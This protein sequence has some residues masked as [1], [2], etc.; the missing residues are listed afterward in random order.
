MKNNLLI[1]FL[2]LISSQLLSQHYETEL[3]G[4][5]QG[6]AKLNI[7][8]HL[9]EKSTSSALKDFRIYGLSNQEDTIEVPYIIQS[10]TDFHFSESDPFK[11]INQASINGEFLYTIV[12]EIPKII[13]TIQLDISQNNFDWK[14]DIEGSQNQKE[15]YKITQNY[16]IMSIENELTDYKFTT[17]RIPSSQYKYFRLR[18]K[19]KTKPTITGAT[20]QKDSTIFGKYIQYTIQNIKNSQDKKQKQSVYEITL[21]H[22]VPLSRLSFLINNE[23]DYYRPFRL[24]YSK[25]S[26]RKYYNTITSGVLHSL[27]SSQYETN[28]T[29]VKY[30]KLIIQNFNNPPLD[31]DS[32]ILEGVSEEIV[33]LF[34]DNG[35][36]YW[37]EYGDKN[38]TRPRYDI[39]HFDNTIPKV[40][41]TLNFGIETYK[42]PISSPEPKP[43]FNQTWLWSIMLV[44]I[45]ILAWFSIKML[46]S[47]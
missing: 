37:A 29:S 22:K 10:H 20:S 47:S 5:T 2:L 18:V 45:G 46:K 28:N 32:I 13:N 42:K 11:I 31:I 35:T 17:I 24:S 26:V 1:T 15:W 27:N 16:R 36:K 25:D 14:V 30:L 34:P 9:Y 40:I 7:P 12:Q 6:W 8:E 44:I 41:P 43:L 3:N 33:A 23:K 21:Q 4:T 19:S 38:K 39:Q